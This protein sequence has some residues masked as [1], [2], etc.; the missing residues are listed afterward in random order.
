MYLVSF[1]SNL[2]AP[3][4][5]SK[6]EGQGRKHTSP[7]LQ[8]PRAE[9]VSAVLCHQRHLDHLVYTP[10]NGKFARLS[11]SRPTSTKHKITDISSC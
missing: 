8:Y 11:V 6:L 1:A 9:D 2:I 3:A 4:S 10:S 5:L 7:A